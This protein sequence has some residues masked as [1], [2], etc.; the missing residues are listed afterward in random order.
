MSK[1]G[2]HEDWLN[3]IERAQ[4]D[5]QLTFTQ[6]KVLLSLPRFFRRDDGRIYPSHPTVAA[7]AG[8]SIRTVQRTLK[9]A[10]EMGLVKR[11]ARY[12]RGASEVYELPVPGRAS[13]ARP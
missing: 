12:V 4:L 8:C 3:L 1:D 11:T 10:R 5:G 7:R 9:A 6:E 2:K 13:G